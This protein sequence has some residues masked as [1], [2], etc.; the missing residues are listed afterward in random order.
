MTNESLI[1]DLQMSRRDFW[2]CWMKFLSEERNPNSVE[3]SLSHHDK[4]SNQQEIDQIVEDSESGDD[5]EAKE[6]GC[7]EYLHARFSRKR[8]LRDSFFEE[9]IMVISKQINR[10]LL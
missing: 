6:Y 8:R 5:E 10:L 9:E 4:A 1:L 2:S 7:L 3:S